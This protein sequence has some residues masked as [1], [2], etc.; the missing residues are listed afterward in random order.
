M[1]WK[2]NGASRGSDAVDR[3]AWAQPYVIA[4]VRDREL[5]RG[6]SRAATAGRGAVDALR[7]ESP[8]NALHLLATDQR[9][10]RR[11][12]GVAKELDDA[13]TGVGI[14]AAKTRKR[15][16]G[17]LVL[18]VMGVLAVIAGVIVAGDDE[19]RAKLRAKIGGGA[20]EGPA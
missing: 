15:R 12:G 17:R 6:L 19:T 5:Q 10:Q 1:A 14:A 9:L 2:S 20:G 13:L 7:G 4:A 16:R 3:I 18:I 8:R 11:L